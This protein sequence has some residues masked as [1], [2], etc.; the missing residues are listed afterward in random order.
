[1][2]DA[3]HKQICRNEARREHTEYQRGCKFT[4]DKLRCPNCRTI[5]DC[6]CTLEQ[7]QAAWGRIK[8]ARR[9]EYVERIR[10]CDE[11]LA[12]RQAEWEKQHG[13]DNV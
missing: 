7:V 10:R 8:A 2:T 1:M 11:D 3:E 4:Q 5:W 13:D 9:A 6:N 12:R